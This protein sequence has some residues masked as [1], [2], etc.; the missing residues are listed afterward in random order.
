MTPGCWER[1]LFGILWAAQR[2]RFCPCCFPPP[3][4]SL[5]LP[6]CSSSLLFNSDLLSSIPDSI[7]D[8]GAIAVTRQPSQSLPWYPSLKSTAI[9]CSQVTNKCVSQKRVSKNR[10]KDTLAN[11]HDARKPRMVILSK[12]ALLPGPCQ[13]AVNLLITTNL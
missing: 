1:E 13:L 2:L 7:L 9:A 6:S 11:F 4:L 12:A 3:S 5:P 10:R 8:T